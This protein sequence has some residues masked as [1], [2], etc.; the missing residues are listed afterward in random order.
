MYSMFSYSFLGNKV[1]VMQNEECY[2]CFQYSMHVALSLLTQ[3]FSRVTYFLSSLHTTKTKDTAGEFTTCI[4]MSFYER[5]EFLTVANWH[6]AE[7][8]SETASEQLRVVARIE[9]LI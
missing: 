3:N 1:V 8:Q 5:M 2:S 4:L 7:L 6:L 9:V